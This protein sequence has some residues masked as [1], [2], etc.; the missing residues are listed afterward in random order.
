MTLRELQEKRTGLLKAARARLDEINSNTD[1]SRTA[2]LEAQHD[3]GLAVL[4]ALDVKIKRSQDM[5]AREEAAARDEEERAN[6]EQRNRENRRP[7]LG[8]GET[9]AGGSGGEQPAATH[10]SVFRHYLQHGAADLNTEE[11]AILMQ[12]RHMPARGEQRAQATGTDAAGGYIVPEALA[13]EIDKAM[14]VWGPMWDA[15]IVRELPTSA[16]NPIPWPTVDDTA[17]TGALK[18]ENASVTDDGGNDVVFGEKTLG[19]YIYDTEMVR[20]PIELLQ[21]AAFD[22]PALME[23][24]FGE[25]LGRTANTALTTGSGSGQPNGI[26][27]AAS[28]GK[29]AASATALDA[30]EI[31][32][33]VHSVDPA[34][35]ASP[36]CRFQFND[37]TLGSLRKLKD[38]D[39]NYLW[40]MGDVRL[41]EPALILDKPFSVNQAMV[42]AATGTVP[43]I[44]GDHGRYIVRKVNGF[45]V[46]TLRERYAEKFQVGMIGFKRFDGELLNTAA[47]KKLTMA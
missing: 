3:A 21:D 11:R 15:D 40:Q 32:D 6:A 34:Y 18:A 28:A 46:L 22:V 36:K 10:D 33:L 8:G 26:V 1:E 23:D 44:F 37:T 47:V 41:G 13:P 31:I 4:D 38:G 35:R 25:R 12:H 14:A 5:T 16:G 7:G 29:T 27:T 45:I 39:G 2:E 9:P 24:L 19:A 20:I 17:K 30:D 43:I 42:D